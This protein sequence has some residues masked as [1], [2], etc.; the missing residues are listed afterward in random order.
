MA[1]AIQQPRRL[2][3]QLHSEQQQPVDLHLTQTFPGQTLQAQK[4]QPSSQHGMPQQQE[5]SYLAE[6]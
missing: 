6:R 3:K 2:G 4:M 1:Q 5:I